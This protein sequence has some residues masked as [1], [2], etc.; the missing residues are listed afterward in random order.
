MGHA[1]TND[2]VSE[3]FGGPGRRRGALGITTK[4]T[5][6][7]NTIRPLSLADALRALE[8]E[9]QAMVQQR[10]IIEDDYGL[11]IGDNS[12]LR[13]YQYNVAGSVARILTGDFAVPGKPGILPETPP[14]SAGEM[15]NLARELCRDAA[16]ETGIS[17]EEKFGQ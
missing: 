17:L 14:F 6:T 15:H 3:H 11:A 2:A 16:Q 12:F 4:D 8:W 9:H 13:E 7:G 1:L 10:D 5:A